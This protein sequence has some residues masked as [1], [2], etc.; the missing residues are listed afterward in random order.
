M[1]DGPPP[2]RLVADIGGTYG[3]FAL[4]WPGRAPEPPG[5]LICADYPELGAAIEA[6]LERRAPELAPRQAALAVAGPV[7]G[8]VVQI[9]NHPWR[10][11][12]QELRR[13]LGLERLVVINDFSALSLSLPHLSDAELRPIGGGAPVPGAPKAVLGPGTGLGVAG[14][15]P[16]RDGWLPLAGEGGHVDFVP[17]DEREVEIL[18]RLKRRWDHVSAERLLS[19]PGLVSLYQIL[20]KLEAG[21]VGEVPEAPTPEAVVEAARAAEDGVAGA[22]LRTFCAVLGAVAGDL[23]LTLG[24][25]GGVYLAGGIVPRLGA[26]FDERGF[27]RRFEAKGRF[28]DYLARIP[29]YVVM[30]AHPTLLGLAR[31]LDDGV[32]PWGAQVAVPD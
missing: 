7:T 14:L 23:A 8:D 21:A 12:S 11:S 26:A 4:S 9:T 30:A 27:R 20:A 16:T 24:A 6:F 25:L 1:V 31:C 22:A 5:E 2:P 19:G 32:A 29:V 10:F 28:A 13:R 17:G 15:V 18:R 3:R